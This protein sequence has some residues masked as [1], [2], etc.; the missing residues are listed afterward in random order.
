[1]F[2]SGLLRLPAG[3]LFRAEAFLSAAHGSDP[4]SLA[5]DA[6]EK[7]EQDRDTGVTD[8]ERVQVIFKGTNSKTFLFQI[9]NLTVHT[10]VLLNF[11]WT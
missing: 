6:K 3:A 2:F 10:C 8:K 4:E 7:Q 11:L 5:N 9:I 1:M